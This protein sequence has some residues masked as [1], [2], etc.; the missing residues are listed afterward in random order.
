MIDQQHQVRFGG[1]RDIE[2]ALVDPLCPSSAVRTTQDVVRLPGG[3]VALNDDLAAAVFVVLERGGASAGFADVEDFRAVRMDSDA[4]FV[5]P[6]DCPLRLGGVWGRP[7]NPG[8]LVGGFSPG[9]P[10]A[11]SAAVFAGSN[12]DGAIFTGCKK[13]SKPS[14]GSISSFARTSLRLAH[15]A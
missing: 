3:G 9:A 11:D 10:A 1:Q 7:P 4:H 12:P 2:G 6:T 13:V 15:P 14:A 5:T 8:S